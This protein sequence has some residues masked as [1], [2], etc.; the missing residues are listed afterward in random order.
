MFI[1]T[2]Q[3]CTKA[4][5]VQTKCSSRDIWSELVFFFM[6]KN[7][8]IR[9]EVYNNGKYVGFVT[10]L[11]SLEQL[12]EYL[13][14]K[15]IEFTEVEIIEAVVRKPTIRYSTNSWNVSINA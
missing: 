15:K 7:K 2:N 3:S 6:K 8:C 14:K 1:V 12:L 9:G 5:L 13:V 11:I 4:Y 10:E